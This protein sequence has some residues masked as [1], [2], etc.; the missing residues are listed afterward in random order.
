MAYYLLLFLYGDFLYFITG[1]YLVDDVYSFYYFSETG[2]V[3]IKVLGI[4]PVV[5]DKE[6]GSSCVSSGMGHRKNT[7]VMILVLPC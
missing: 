2:V 3:S 5:A 1:L 6:L 7:F 4:F